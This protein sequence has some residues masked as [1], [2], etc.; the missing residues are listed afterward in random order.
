MSQILSQSLLH[1]M[2]MEQRLTPQLIQSM[3]ILQKPV[4]DLETYIND[5]LESNSAL[6]IAEPE[7]SVPDTLEPGLRDGIGTGAERDQQSFAR[8]DRYSRDYDLDFNDRLPFPSRRPAPSDE[9]D[10]KMGA[11]ANTA[12]REI[13]LHDHLLSQWGLAELDENIRRAGEAIIVNIDPDGYLRVPF[14]VIV[15]RARAPIP[16]EDL[17]AALTEVQRLEPVGVGARDIVECLLL[18]LE[19][20]PGDNQ[21]ER[22]LIEKHLRDVAGNRLPAVSKATGYSIGEINEALKVIRSTLRLHPGYLVGDH[23]VPAIRPDV[24]VD[25]AETGGGFI[26]RLT[27][28]NIPEL[29]LSNE[30]VAVAKSKKIEKETRDFAR[31]QIES[32]SALIDAVTFRKNRLMDVARAIVEKQR[33]FFDIGPE[34]LKVFRMSELALELGCDPSTISR[35]VADK[36]IQTP[37]GIYPLRYFFTGGT[38]TDEGE[39]VGWDRVKTRVRE[40]V[41]AE[42]RKAPYSDD[43]I[44]AI[45]KDEGVEISRRTV[46]KYRHQMKIPNARQRREY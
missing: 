36:Y 38:E 22:T 32:A 9:R 33:E 14:E 24:I 17:Q 34:G 43:R 39:S 11:L 10:A 46:A 30:V 21:V 18:Q 23:S 40:L 8:L 41:D 25:Y 44:A 15:E 16:L 7:P 35:T 19:A 42:D 31:K 37:R 26:V 29:R 27:R 6:E 4:A 1:Q 12:D 3:S 20:L 2:R 45:L 5:A 13:S 28:G